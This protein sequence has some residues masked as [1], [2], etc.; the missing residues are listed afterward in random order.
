MNEMSALLPTDKTPK[1]LGWEKNNVTSNELR[2][3]DRVLM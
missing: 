3:N 1:H 2:G